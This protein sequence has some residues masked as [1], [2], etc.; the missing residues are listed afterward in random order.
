MSREQGDHLKRNEVKTGIVDYILKQKTPIEEPTI[1]DYVKN[2]YGVS[3][4]STIRAHLKDL[5]DKY[6]CVGKTPGSPGCANRWTINTINHLLKIKTHFPIINLKKYNTSIDI[7]R[8]QHVRDGDLNDAI[9]TITH[10]LHISDAFFLMC[11]THDV[12]DLYTR[13]LSL[14]QY[15]DGY[16]TYRK[17]HNGEIEKDEYLRNAKLSLIPNVFHTCVCQDILNGV[18]TNEALHKLEVNKNISLFKNNTSAHT[19]RS[20]ELQQLIDDVCALAPIMSNSNKNE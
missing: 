1:R 18:A 17:L 6:K 19:P 12:D 10:Y 9:S 3:D 5:K 7:I 11:L 2:K 4:N 14:Y 8:R 15:T 20:T 16:E 13:W